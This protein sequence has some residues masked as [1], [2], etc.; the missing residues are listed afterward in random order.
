MIFVKIFWIDTLEMAVTLACF[1]VGIFWRLTLL[2]EISIIA[3]TITIIK[4][5]VFRQ[6]L[7]LLLQGFF[8]TAIAVFVVGLF[9]HTGAI[10]MELIVVTI[11]TSAVFINWVPIY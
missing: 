7:A 2:L 3:I 8:I 10:I 9:T 5:G 1:I 11:S 6:R 4:V